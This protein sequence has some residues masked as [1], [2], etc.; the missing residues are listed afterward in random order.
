MSEG[1]QNRIGLFGGTFDPIHYGHLRAA[2]EIRY[3]LNLDKV[4]FIPTSTPP[5]KENSG[6]SQAE[7]R[8][9]MI[10]L[11]IDENKYFEISE[12]ELRSDAPSYTIYTL[13]HFTQ[14]EQDTEFYFIVGNELFNEIENWRD[15]KKLFELSNFAVITRPG[16]S[17]LDSSKIPLA[18]KDDFRY[19]NSIENVISY[20][21]KV[22]EIVFIEI[23][24]I[25]ISSTDIRGFV[26][27]KQS[28]KYLVPDKVEKYI[29]SQKLYAGEATQ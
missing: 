4:L 8:L 7:D 21:N 6:I 3:I 14:N 5:H 15:Y 1:K 29:R 26:K 28:I 19:H 20:N 10:R 24:G 9:E 22:K 25:E 27:S 18:L 13:E 2:E 12:Y 16:F 17:E 23:K 11:A